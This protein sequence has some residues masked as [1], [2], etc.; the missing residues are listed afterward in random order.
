M[1]LMDGPVQ[2]KWRDKHIRHVMVIWS[3]F[4]ARPSCHLPHDHFSRPEWKVWLPGAWMPASTRLGGS[5][6]VPFLP[7]DAQI[8]AEWLV[9]MMMLLSMDPAEK[10]KQAHRLIITCQ[11]PCLNDCF[12]LWAL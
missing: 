4:N 5:S 11:P 7:K 9:M 2:K 10:Q 8:D 1:D 6:W 3:L 12:D